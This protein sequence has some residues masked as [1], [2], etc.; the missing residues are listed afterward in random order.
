MEQRKQIMW[1][2]G[3]GVPG[4]DFDDQQFGWSVLGPVCLKDEH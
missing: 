4:S 1:E 3:T 2:S